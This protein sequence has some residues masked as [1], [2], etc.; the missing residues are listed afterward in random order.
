MNTSRNR[1]GQFTKGH[2]GF[3]PKGAISRKTR[4]GQNR[5]MELF[6][7]IDQNLEDDIVK[8]GHNERIQLWLRLAKSLQLDAPLPESQLNSSDPPINKIVFEVVPSKKPPDQ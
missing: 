4:Q 3:K 6:N 5:M 7:L 8:L 2:K 1:N